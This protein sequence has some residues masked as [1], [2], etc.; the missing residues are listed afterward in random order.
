MCNI[1]FK[2]GYYEWNVFVDDEYYYTFGEGITED[3]PYNANK[4]D[5][6][7]AV[8]ELIFCMNYDLMNNE[9]YNGRLPLNDEQTAEL[10]KQM[11]TELSYY[12]CDVKI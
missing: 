1:E 2:A 7:N 10:K 12:C 6:E 11:I 3:I 8:D 9:E 5:M 4:D